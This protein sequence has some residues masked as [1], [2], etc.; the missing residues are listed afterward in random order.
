V[1]GEFKK[2]K[3]LLCRYMSARHDSPLL[4]PTDTEMQSIEKVRA[5][6]RGFENVESAA[7]RPSEKEWFENTKRLRELILNDDPRE[8]LRWDVILK[9]M[10]VTNASYVCA[11]LKYLKSRL[12]WGDRW[13]E[14][15]CE[16]RVGHPLPYWRYPKSS[17]NLITHAYHLARFEEET[18]MRANDMSFIFEFGGGYGSMS[19]LIHHL[20]FEGKY[21]LFDLP[22]F[23]ALQKFFLESLGLPLLSSETF[24]SARGGILCISDMEELKGILSASVESKGSMFIATWSISETPVELRNV[25]LPLVRSFEGFLIGYQSQFREVNNIDFFKRWTTDQGNVQWYEWK[26]AHIPNHNRYLVGRRRAGQQ[27]KRK[28]R[29]GAPGCDG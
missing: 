4:A 16:S 7:C 23:S 27:A 1:F 13:E 8:F 29:P 19:R 14:A 5:T 6:F 2:L 26:I 24:E 25:I 11:E 20:G 10:A 22:A 21:V 28:H 17:G 18:V 9:T 12:D 3:R 15:I